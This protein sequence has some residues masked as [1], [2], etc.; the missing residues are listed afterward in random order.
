MKATVFEE[1]AAIPAAVVA[2]QGPGD[3]GRIQPRKNLLMLANVS[4]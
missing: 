1:A 3:L 2:V 4:H